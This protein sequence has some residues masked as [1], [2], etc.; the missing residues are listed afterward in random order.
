MDHLITI[1]YV[2]YFKNKTL[3]KLE[4]RILQFVKDIKALSRE[5][6]LATVNPFHTGSL[7]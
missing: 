2:L 1:F 5:M 7:N 3:K 4:C 6:H